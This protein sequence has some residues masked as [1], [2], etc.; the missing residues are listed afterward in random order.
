MARSSNVGDLQSGKFWVA[1]LAEFIG[2]ALLVTVGCGSCY[3]GSS[4][5]GIALSFGLSVGTIVW[6]IAGVSGGHINPA[7]TIGFLATRKIS[8]VR[9]LFYIVSQ[10][11]GAIAGAGLLRM[12]TPCNATAG[13]NPNPTLGTSTPP[14]DGSVTNFQIF[15]IE[16]TITFVL[17]FTVFATCDS[18]RKGFGGSGPLAIGLSVTM[19]HLWAVAFTGAGTNPARVF[20]PAVVSHTW[21]GHWA[22]WLGPIVGGITAATLYDFV[23]AVN[24]SRAKLAGFFTSDYDDDDF[25]EGGRKSDPAKTRDTELSGKSPS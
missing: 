10:S 8:L 13:V 21:V 15:L 25:D 14:K 4:H 22:Y 19:G 18:R 24:A 1:L 23:M 7:V 5:V 3:A 17:V 2:T 6:A 11:I 12:V 20:G 16:Q 9:G